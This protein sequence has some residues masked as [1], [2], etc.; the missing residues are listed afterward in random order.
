MQKIKLKAQ[1]FCLKYVQYKC[2]ITKAAKEV[3]I[4]V[5]KANKLLKDAD[6]QVY[7]ADLQKEIQD[8][9]KINQK[10]QI[11][12]LKKIA[13]NCMKKDDEGKMFSASAGTQA[14]KEV[15]VMLG[16]DKPKPNKMDLGGV[17]IHDPVAVIAAALKA[18]SDRDIS[19][20]DLDAVMKAM[21][22]LQL[23]RY[24]ADL[25]AQLKNLQMD[26]NKTSIFNQPQK[27]IDV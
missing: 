14:I 9:V 20:E 26:K 27:V 21:D 16:L 15:S 23:F 10:K 24:G 6:T 11:K 19:K 2:D 18:Y 4:S 25:E 7:I 12:K 22:T 5:P 13:K 17:N 8:T 1:L 3:G